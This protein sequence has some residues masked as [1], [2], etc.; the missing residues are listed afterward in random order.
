MSLDFVTGLLPV[1][2]H[3]VIIVV[4]DRLSKYCH[5]GSLPTSYS[6]TTVADYFVKNIIRLHGIPKK[7]VSDRDK[8]FLSKFWQE[9]FK[10]SGTTLSMSTAYHMESN[11]Q[12]EIVN[13]TIEV[14]L[15][16]EIH[17]NLRTWIDLLPWAEL[18]YN[19]T[20][21]YSADTS[22]F[23]IVY[24]RPPLTLTPYSAGDSRVE[25]VD[26]ELLRRKALLADLRI[27]LLG[28]QDRMKKNADRKRKQF[29]FQEKDWVW[30]KLQP[31][32]QS[33]VNFCRCEKLSKRYYS[34]FQITRKVSSVAYRL[35]LPSGSTIFPVFHISLLK[36]FI[37]NLEECQRLELP[38]KAVDSHP[39]ATP[40]EI[41]GYRIVSVKG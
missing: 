26:K 13:K 19:I 11:G 21:H 35:A 5:I 25:V 2:G 22:P 23:E 16:V 31:Y 30:L 3:A 34:P 18:W 39:I 7:M 20:Y 4:V 37:G 41:V 15:R 40:T 36:L 14:Y 33:S 6:A 28:A 10:K 29:E 1:N 9:V 24:G 8:V 17:S 38:E 27:H 32:R 12:T